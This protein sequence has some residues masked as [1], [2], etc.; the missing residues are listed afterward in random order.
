M[1]KSVLILG[2]HGQVATSIK[3]LAPSHLSKINFIF[4]S[5]NSID[6]SESI[7]S[8]FLKIINQYNPLLVINTAAYTKVDLAEK[9]KELASQINGKSVGVIAEICGK[10]GIPLF[11][12]STDYVFDGTSISDISPSDKTKPLCSYGKSKLLGEKLITKSIDN[13]GTKALVIRTSWVF[14]SHG[15]NF[16]HK[17]LKLA[18]GKSDI[19]VV[20]DQFGGPT[21]SDSIALALLKLIDFGIN[22]QHPTIKYKPFPWGTFHFQGKPVVNWN[23]FASNIMND[24]LSIGLIDRSRKVL[25]TSTAN[26]TTPAKR[27]LNCSLNCTSSEKELGLILPDWRKDLQVVLDQIFNSHNKNNFESLED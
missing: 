1:M 20:S 24:A 18:K 25:E 21:S 11:H 5:R 12:I 27:P 23:Q 17:I 16:V 15:D 10:K 26:F 9:E 4:L 19:R 6:L 7:R 3:N 2:K 14:S 13:F 8:K 22:N